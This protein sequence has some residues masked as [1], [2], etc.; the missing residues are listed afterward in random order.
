MARSTK[1]E[2][3]EAQLEALYRK[4]EHDLIA[5][6]ADD[7]ERGNLGSARYR[8]ARI[9]SVRELLSELQDKAVPEATDLATL[10]YQEGAK[11]AA[12]ATGSTLPS[13][14]SGQH[15]GAMEMLADNLVSGLNGAAEMV[16]RRVEDAYRKAG[17]EAASQQ[18]AQ[19]GTLRDATREL[20]DLLRSQ[21]LNAGP[22]GAANWKLSRYA[23]MVIRTNTTDAITRGNIN[24]AT[25]DGYDLVEVLAIGDE[26][27]CEICGSFVGQVYTLG[28]RDGY[29]TLTEFPPFHPNCRCDLNIL[30][31]D[32]NA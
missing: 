22:G 25:E 32:P 8:R 19:G 1:L 20:I 29:E 7:L 31:K 21:G 26:L 30:T 23:E 17:L 24:T 6:L 14:G 9:A 16:G 18:I 2:R 27:L 12:A 10:A 3:A 28:E 11:Q 13:F 4:A 5:Q 15:L